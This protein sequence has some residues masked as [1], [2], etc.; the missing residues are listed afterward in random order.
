MKNIWNITIPLILILFPALRSPTLS[1]SGVFPYQSQD[2]PLRILSS[3]DSVTGVVV[4]G[5]VL[6][7]EAETAGSPN[8]YSIRYLRASHSL[9]GGV[10]IGSHAVSLNG[11]PLRADQAGTPL[12]DSF[13]HTFVLQEAVR[14]VNH[15]M[16][17]DI[18]ERENALI[19]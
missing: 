9:L 2:Y 5:E 15:N 16:Q 7:P 19:M 10:W 3:K 1:G 14:L 6:F 12:G 4:V 13:Y 8:T 18:G 17:G 11:V